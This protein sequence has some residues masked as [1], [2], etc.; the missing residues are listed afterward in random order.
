MSRKPAKAAPAADTQPSRNLQAPTGNVDGQRFEISP[1]VV[2]LGAFSRRKG[3]EA[4]FRLGAELLIH[5]FDLGRRGLAVCGASE[6]VGVSF[7]AANLGVALSNSGLSVMVIEANLR[8]PRLDRLIRPLQPGPGLL[9]VLEGGGPTL[10]EVTHRDV[11]PHLSLVYAGGVAPNAQDLLESDR[12]QE[13]LESCLRDYD[14]TLV[15]TAPAN[16]SA[17]ARRA[18]AILGY[19]LVVARRGRSYADDIAVLTRE[20][21]QDGAQVIGTVLNAD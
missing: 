10:G 4:V 11:L 14:C 15:D 13:V 20:L 19:A 3:A 8:A 9:Q 16:G 2:T 12:F 18:A 1:E 17:D 6:G 7:L 5:H 21:R